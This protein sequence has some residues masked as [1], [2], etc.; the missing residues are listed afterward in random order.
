MET[1][2]YS[3]AAIDSEPASS[4]ASPAVSRAGAVARRAGHAD[5]QP[6]VDTM[7]SLAP[8]TAARSQLS[9]VPRAPPWASS[10]VGCVTWRRMPSGAPLALHRRSAA[11]SS[12]CRRNPSP[13][14]GTRRRGPFRRAL[15]GPCG[16]GVSVAA[17]ILIDHARD[18]TT[19]PPSATAWPAAYPQG[20]AVV[21]VETT[22]LARD[23]RI[24]SAAVYRLDARGE[25]EDHW[26]TLV[27]PQRDPGPVWIHR[28][29]SDVLG[30]HRSSRTSPRSSR[31]GSTG[32]CSSRTTP[33]STGR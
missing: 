27:N 11:V 21:D 7:P 12:P 8:R 19:A 30:E 24:I 20:Y 32:G 5:D 4:P 31:P 6:A 15:R 14:R 2:T 3:P 17:R 10:C 33:S 23:D 18:R 22:G 25:V 13:A 26:Y 28:L 9:R 1:D 16:S 29:T